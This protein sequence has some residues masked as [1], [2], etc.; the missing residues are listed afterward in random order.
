MPLWD[1]VPSEGDHELALVGP[2]EDHK[3]DERAGAPLL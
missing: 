1:P 2:E 3:V